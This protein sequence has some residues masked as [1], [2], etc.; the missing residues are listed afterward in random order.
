MKNK[1][2]NKMNV[3]W[4]L[5]LAISV[6]SCGTK[7][8]KSGEKPTGLAAAKV[9]VEKVKM[10]MQTI[11]YKYSGVIEPSVQTNLSFQSIGKVQQILVDEGDYVSK[12][13]VLA[14]LDDVSATAA[15]KASMASQKQAQ[16]AY[17]RLKT[18]YEKGSLPDIKWEEMKTNLEQANASTEMAKQRLNNMVL[19]APYSGVIGARNIELGSSVNPATTAFE[20]VIIDKVFARISVP[21][22]EISKFKKGQIADVNIP[23]VGANNFVGEVEKIGIVANKLT[24]TYAVKIN[25]INNNL[26]IKPGMVCD[27]KVSIGQNEHSLSVPMQAVINQPNE[28][29]YVFVVNKQQMVNK[30][31]IKIGKFTNSDVEVL[32]GLHEGDFVVVNGQ[33]KLTNNMQVSF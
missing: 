10:I 18:V 25:V 26:L 13:D 11:T 6:S 23:A 20:I 31:R 14:K 27:T 15:Y 29:P 19:R 17:D 5:A 1:R 9:Q 32:S 16:D 28:N 21:E 3:I 30:R 33:H 4:I 12:G 22:H 7:A 8:A 24:K 2:R